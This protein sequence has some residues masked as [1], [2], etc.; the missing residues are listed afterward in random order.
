MNFKHGHRGV[1]RNGKRAES[2]TMGT[3]RG[4]LKRCGDPR[5]PSYLNYGARGIEV[6][7]RWKAFENFLADMGERP[8]EMSLDRID[9][10]R[11]YEPGNC[12]WATDAEQQRHRSNNKLT[13]DQAN[14]IRRLKANGSRSA[15][16]ARQFGVSSRLV[17]NIANNLAWKVTS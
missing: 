12:R 14:E 3:W 4:M 16:V 11:G 2:R 15:D 10:D 9:N 13:A 1:Y 5:S 8:D 6:C 17:R 7:E